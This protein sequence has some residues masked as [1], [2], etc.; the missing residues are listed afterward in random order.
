MA[1]RSI[2]KVNK[3]KEHERVEIISIGVLANVCYRDSWRS[4]ITAGAQ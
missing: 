1:V 4:A 3:R 2:S